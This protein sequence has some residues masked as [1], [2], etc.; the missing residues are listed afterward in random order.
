M[1]DDY[2]MQSLSRLHRDESM[3]LPVNYVI[4]E[5]LRADIVRPHQTSRERQM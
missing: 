3:Q 5:T 1:A 2:D 4:L